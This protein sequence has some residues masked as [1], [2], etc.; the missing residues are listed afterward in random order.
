MQGVNNQEVLPKMPKYTP[1]LNRGCMQPMKRIQVQWSWITRLVLS[2]VLLITACGHQDEESHKINSDEVQVYLGLQR[3]VNALAQFVAQ[4][5]NPQDEVNYGGFKTVQEVAVLLDV[6]SE[7]EWR[8]MQYLRMI[9][10][11]DDKTRL[12][13]IESTYIA[14]VS[15][16]IAEKCFCYKGTEDR[17]TCIPEPLQET[18]TEPAAVTQVM[19]VE[20]TTDS[21]AELMGQ[22]VRSDSSAI[23]TDG[24]YRGNDGTPEG[25]AEGVATGAYT[26]NQYRMAYNVDPP[27]AGGGS[28]TGKGVRVAILNS[29][30]WVFEDIAV[31]TGCFQDRKNPNA[32]ITKLWSDQISIDY[33]AETYMDTELVLAIAPD[34]EITSLTV[35]SNYVPAFVQGLAAILDAN[36]FHGGLPHVVSSSFIRCEGDLTKDEIGL[37]ETYLMA[38]AAVGISVVSSSGDGGFLNG[39][40]GSVQGAV[41]PAS[42]PYVTGAGGTNMALNKDNT[43]SEETVW[44]DSTG[45]GQSGGGPSGLFPIPT[46]Q[47][48][49][50]IDEHKPTMRLTPDVA[51]FANDDNPGLAFYGKQLFERTS[52]WMAMGG[53]TSASAPMFAGMVALCVQQRLDSGK[54]SLGLL[55]PLLYQM[56]GSTEY[57]SLFRDITIGTG[58]NDPA[59]TAWEVGGASRGYDMATGWGSPMA[60]AMADYIN[61]NVP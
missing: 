23:E 45:S 46:W 26:P 7:A 24:T 18:D 27:S 48:G 36:N 33:M 40:V 44:M 61:L 50:G 47:K 29:F 2:L 59:K 1:S 19:I 54:S 52:H 38:A 13:P 9:D 41:Y 49:Q 34:S 53:G 6:S 56:A 32:K 12:D 30:H 39:C 55:N 4:V 17:S 25:C 21:N 51:L 60:L 20:P 22:Q 16:D 15:V 42:S 28:L 57:N 43:I 58:N 3:N 11:P 35:G 5:S 14:T 31:F 10:I 8:V 37:A